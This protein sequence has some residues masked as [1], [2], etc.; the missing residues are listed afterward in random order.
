MSS[1]SESLKKEHFKFDCLRLN[2]CVKGIL[3]QVPI[4]SQ[5]VPLLTQRFYYQ[6]NIEFRGVFLIISHAIDT[7]LRKLLLKFL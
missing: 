1:H 5:L 6:L 3:P 7:E 2:S 4:I